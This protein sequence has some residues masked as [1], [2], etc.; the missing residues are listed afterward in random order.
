[1]EGSEAAIAA[2][3]GVNPI[4]ISSGNSVRHRLN[5][6]GDRQL[7]KALH[8]IA[9]TRMQ[10]DATT[11]DY[12]VRRTAEGKSIKEIRRCLKRAIARQLFRRIQNLM[13]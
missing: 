10:F 3:A 9:R 2:I 5:R 11:K 13:A 4:P 1:M 6:N 7:N 8:T 12:V